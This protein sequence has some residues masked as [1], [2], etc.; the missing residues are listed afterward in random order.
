MSLIRTE[1][2]TRLYHLGD[3]TV[4]ALAGVSLDVEPGEFVAVMGPS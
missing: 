4:T 3:E 2:L 1:N